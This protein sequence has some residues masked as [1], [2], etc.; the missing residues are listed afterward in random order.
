MDSIWQVRIKITQAPEPFV[1]NP[2][3]ENA[4]LEWH[5]PENI[6]TFLFDPINSNPPTSFGLELTLEKKLQITFF[7]KAQSQIDGY[8]IAQAWLSSLRYKFVGLDAEIEVN[9]INQDDIRKRSID[10]FYEIKLPSGLTLKRINI[11]RKFINA[12]YHNSE[13]TIKMFIIWQQEQDLPNLLMEWSL[14][15]AV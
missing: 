6:R 5:E 7:T 8:E 1:P 9:Q 15:A 11:I 3:D 12:F 4:L 13:Q 2:F 10:N 14:H